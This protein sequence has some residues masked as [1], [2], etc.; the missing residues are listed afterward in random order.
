MTAAQDWLVQKTLVKGNLKA[1]L[2][3]GV[4]LENARA[5]SNWNITLEY[6][7]FAEVSVWPPPPGPAAVPVN[8]LRESVRLLFSRSSERTSPGPLENAALDVGKL[9]S[10]SIPNIPE[11][12]ITQIAF[13][14][15]TALHH[16]E[17]SA[18]WDFD[19]TQIS[20]DA[21]R[22]TFTAGSHTID[23][24]ITD[25]FGSF[26]VTASFEVE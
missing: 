22:L 6:D 4:P 25:A 7:T 9:Y 1:L 24:Q 19:G 3:L 18:P 14:F 23:A 13:Y 8:G 2:D 12:G 20:G 26:G 17:L 11:L 5:M 16:T 21:N 10:V 15:D